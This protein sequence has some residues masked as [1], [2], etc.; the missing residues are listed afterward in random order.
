M[1]RFTS[2]CKID[3]NEVDIDVLVDTLTPGEIQALL[4][5]CD[6]DDPHLP[7]SARCTYKCDKLPTGPLNR[8]KLLEFINEQA[9]NT[10]DKPEL[11]PYVPGTIRGKKWVPPPKPQNLLGLDVDDDEIELDIDLGEETEEALRSASTNEIIDLAGI[12]GF[13]A[14]MNQDQY[15]AAQSDK[16]SEGAD[17]NVGWDGITKATPLKW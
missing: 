7:A 3:W 2:T 5:E 16:W 10:P 1:S 11:V 14:M 13:H 6:P 12:L 15:H 4:D 8:K 17:S 9:K